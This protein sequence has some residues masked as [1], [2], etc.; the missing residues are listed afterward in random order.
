MVLRCETDQQPALFEPHRSQF[1]VGGFLHAR[2]KETNLV[3]ACGFGPVQGSVRLLENIFHAFIIL[4]KQ[5]YA[6]ADGGLQ[7]PLS[8]F[9][10]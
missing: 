8:Y 5:R 6:D 9:A 7:V 10:G 2:Q 3:A 4:R 1:L